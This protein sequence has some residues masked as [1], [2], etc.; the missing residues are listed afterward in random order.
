M[1]CMQFWVS[2]NIDIFYYQF[3]VCLSSRGCDGI[4]YVICGWF[5]F[6][7]AFQLEIWGLVNYPHL[8]DICWDLDFKEILK[9]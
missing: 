9:L 5:S 1:I 3:C 7:F 8:L 2:L 6:Y 4:V